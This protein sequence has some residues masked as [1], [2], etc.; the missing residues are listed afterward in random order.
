MEIIKTDIPDIQ[1]IKPKIFIDKRGYFL[2]SYNETVLER[3]GFKQNFVQDNESKS[4]KGV[5]RGLHFQCPPFAQGKLVRVIHG[6]VLDV[7]VDIRKG[8]PTYGKWYA[9]ELTGKNKWMLWIPQGFAHGFLTLE[10][11]TIFSYK[12]TQVYNKESESSIRWNDRDINIDWGDNL[13]PVL[14]EKDKEAPFFK[15]FKSPFHY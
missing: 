4:M 9:L 12:C 1:I 15:D 2:E 14:S 11:H 10:D 3:L 5:L 8:S 6:A 13:A 7:A